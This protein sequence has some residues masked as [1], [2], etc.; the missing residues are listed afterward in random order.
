MNNDEF[1]A[2]CAAIGR[3]ETVQYRLKDARSYTDWCI[4]K[5]GHTHFCHGSYEWRIRPRTKTVTLTY[6]APETIA[7]ANCTRYWVAMADQKKFCYPASWNGDDVDRHR[8]RCGR[9]HLTEANAIEHGKA[10]AGQPN[11]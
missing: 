5:T 6:P 11:E 2:L 10:E 3:G 8:L 4:E 1:M 9:V 7:P